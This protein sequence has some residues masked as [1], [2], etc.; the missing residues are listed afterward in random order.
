M[1]KRPNLHI[2]EDATSES[3]EQMN[4]QRNRMEA[5]QFRDALTRASGSV[6]G[7]KTNVTAWRG[8]NV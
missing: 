3:L 1:A 6:V 4:N 2:K 8:W 5:R 7:V